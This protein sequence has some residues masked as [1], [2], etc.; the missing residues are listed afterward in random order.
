MS[1]KAIIVVNSVTYGDTAKNLPR[2]VVADIGN[3]VEARLIGLEPDFRYDAIRIVD[4]SRAKLREQVRRTIKK[5]GE[6]EEAVLFYYFGH[7]V[8]DVDTEALYLFCKDSDRFDP[9]TMLK[10]SEIGEWVRIYHVPELV[11]VFDCCHAGM[12]ASHIRLLDDFDGL[13]YVMASV[14]AKEKALVDYGSEQPLGLFTRHFLQ[15]FGDRSARAHG[16]DVTFAS[17]FEHVRRSIQRT[18]KQEPYSIDGG[19]ANNVFF[20]QTTNPVV[21]PGINL[22]APK[23]SIYKKL[24]TIGV[25]L[26]NHEFASTRQLHAF[27]AHRGPQEFLQPVKRPDG[28]VGYQFVTL[29]S[30]EGY[31]YFSRELGML[32]DGDPVGLTA[33]GKKMIRNTG[34]RYNIELLELL[35]A[36][37]AR[38]GLKIEDLE[39]AIG[40]RLRGNSIPSIDGI[41][42]DLILAKKLFIPKKKFRMLLDLTAD[43]G[44]L[45]YSSDKT[46][47]LASSPEVE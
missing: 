28:A 25:T 27:L 11:L 36:V 24:F 31:I 42:A 45:E 44:A 10:F 14:N 7:A 15:A 22:G 37:W 34:A 43:V 32:A 17:L 33:A 16:R 23:K 3:Q 8:R 47:F 20:R 13:F 30:F 38:A 6:N 29:E 40:Q 39:D 2:H 1:R 19:V 12:I 35:K 18:S 21:L 5:A 26:V 9:P 4:Q 46:F 41:Y